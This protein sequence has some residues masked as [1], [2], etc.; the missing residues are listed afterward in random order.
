MASK[1]KSTFVTSI[2]ISWLIA[3][4]LDAL[5][6]IF[7]LAH[8]HAEAVFR[9]IASAVYGK[10]AFT[11]GT[12]MIWTGVVFHYIIAAAFTVF[13]F[14]SYTY[15]P[16]LRKNTLL[17]ILIYG[18][19][20]WSVMNLL[21]LPLTQVAYTI[22]LAGAVKNILILCVTIALPAVVIRHRYEQLGVSV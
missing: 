11:G 12:S 4:T 8:G 9:Y 7:I 2:I 16:L 5:A 20:A 18:T 14:I 10:E 21:V 22:T 17:V 19:F 1:S 15:V 13:F 6:A 3:G